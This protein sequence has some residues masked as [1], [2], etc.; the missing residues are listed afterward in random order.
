MYGTNPILHLSVSY[1]VM[2]TISWSEHQHL[3]PPRFHKH[4]CSIIPGP[5]AAVKASS[6]M[7]KSKSSVPLLAD[8]DPPEPPPVRYDGLFATAGRPDPVPPAPPGPPL[9]AIA[10]GKTKDGR[11]FPAKPRR[12]LEV[13]RKRKPPRDEYTK[14]RVTRAADI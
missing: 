11:S 3:W 8:K 4:I 13:S 10:V 2:N 9:V 5:L 6:P 12:S 7:K 1:W 14:L